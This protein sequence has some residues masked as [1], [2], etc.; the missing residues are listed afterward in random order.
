MARRRETNMRRLFALLM[1]C[2]SM[3]YFQGGTAA[4]Q[5]DEFVRICDAFGTGFF[6]IPGTDACIR[7]DLPLDNAERIAELEEFF[8][9]AG[10]LTTQLREFEQDIEE[11]KEGTALAIALE[12]PF[13][14]DGK[15]FAVTTNYGTFDGE[16]SL[17]MA[18][19]A[20][21]DDTFGVSGGLG[22][23]LLQGGV[24]GRVGFQASW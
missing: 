21:I 23:G 4:A 18:G 22:V 17:G 10:S 24:A 20:Q 3:L 6:F 12:N 19:V 14:P 8:G 15:N 7:A 13:L 9:P 16:H 1:L 11:S 2:A 5:D